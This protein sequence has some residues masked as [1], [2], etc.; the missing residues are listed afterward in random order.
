MEPAIAALNAT[1]P[2]EYKIE[3]GGIAEESAESQ[4]SVAA[5]VPRRC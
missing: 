4:A 1:L 5:V 3:T 2:P